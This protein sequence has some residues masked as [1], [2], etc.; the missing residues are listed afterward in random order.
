MSINVRVLIGCL[1]LTASVIADQG[2]GGGPPTAGTPPVQGG[3]PGQPPLPDGEATAAISG[4]VIDGGT[5]Q[6]VAGAIV[7]MSILGR[8]VPTGTQPRQLTDDKGRFAFVNVWSDNTYML[9]ASKFGYLDGGVGREKSP[10]DPIRGVRVTKD[11][12]LG[13]VRVTI[14]RPAAISGAVRDENGEPMVGIIVRALVRHRLMGRDELA[15]GP[16]TLTDDRGTYRLAGLVPGRYLMQVPSVQ[17]SMPTKTTYSGPGT[18]NAP[19]GGIELDDTSRL[20]IGRYPL[21]P[22]PVNG[23][24]MTYAMAFHPSTSSVADAMTIELKYGDDRPN[25]DITLSPVPAVRVSGVLEGPPD[26]MTLM[27]VRLL[28]VGLENLGQGS[29]TAT[30]LVDSSG[31]FTFANVPPGS[32]VIDAPVSIYEFSQGGSGIANRPASFPPPPG[33]QSWGRSSN[34]PDAASGL[35]FTTTS[36]RGNNVPNYSGRGSVTVGSSD[37]TGVVVRLKPMARMSG[38]IVLDL[39]PTQPAPETPPR[40]FLSLDP[41]NGEVYLGAPRGQTPPDAPV[42]EFTIP[43]VIPGRYWLRSTGS[44]NWIVKSVTWKGRDY[45]TTPFDTT[46]GDDL[47]GV[48]L[49]MTNNRPTLSGVVQGTDALK[50]EDC[51]VVIFPVERAQ[52]QGYGLTP[53]R[54]RTTSIATGATFTI[55]TLPA[56]DY[57]VAAID[58]SNRARWLDPSVLTQLEAAGA[59]V[60]LTW[61]AKITQS[62]PVVVIR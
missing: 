22:P 33:T 28:P 12:W 52:W 61:G 54:F 23:R 21:P 62:V 3:N 60:S 49:T 4:V 37:V 8:S 31:Q 1:L 15:A 36:F 41:A 55:T 51:M 30:A 16:M 40:F 32:Y 19:D 6:P 59:R 57:V 18:T 20:V 58:R 11:Q 50:A 46:N 14:W 5:G 45:T 24:P 2:R 35:Q 53:T 26:A 44:S 17:A 47:T 13:T 27:T 29:E 7:S 25:V 38:T 42:T 10:A 56:G 39:D 34:A 48:V 43:G 9:S